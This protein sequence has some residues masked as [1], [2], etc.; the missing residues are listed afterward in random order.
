MTKKDYIAIAD[1]IGEAT[2]TDYGGVETRIRNS[3]IHGLCAI[4]SADNP[5]FDVDRFTKRILVQSR[6]NPKE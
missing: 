2:K 5:R 4:F 1:A 3:I 6:D